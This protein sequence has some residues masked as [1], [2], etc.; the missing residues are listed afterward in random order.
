[1]HNL[2]GTYLSE[3]SPKWTRQTCERYQWYLANMVVWLSR[4]KKLKP[5]EVEPD[6]LRGWINDQDWCPSTTHVAITAAKGFFR[7]AVGLRKSPAKD[8]KRPP[9]KKKAHRYL[10][11][12]QV[13]QILSSLDTSDIYGVRNTAIVMLMLDTGLRSS[14][15]CRLKVSDI[16][17]ERQRL[18][19]VVKGGDEEVAVFSE[20]TAQVVGRWL[21]FRPAAANRD[22][23]EVF[24]GIGGAKPGTHMT[25]DGLRAVFRSLGKK[26]GFHFSPHDLR[27]TCGTWILQQGGSTRMAQKLLRLKTLS[28]VETYSPGL[29][30]EDARPYSPVNRIIHDEISESSDPDSQGYNQR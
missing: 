24:V 1:M 8:L 21:D 7:W 23:K 26:A 14:E 19:V 15:V 30:P 17:L 20:Y 11:P 27:R 13:N 2:V 4:H 12:A 16:D 5:E 25:R 3:S 28:L 10:T 6:D 9:R 22:T 18:Q 29:T